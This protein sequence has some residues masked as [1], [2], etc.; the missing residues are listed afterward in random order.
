M[1]FPQ[2]NLHQA[3]TYWAK[4][5]QNQF[6]PIFA[7]PVALKGR[8]IEEQKLFIDAAGREVR[9]EAIVTLNTDVAN[10]GYLF[11]GT[12]TTANPRAVSDAKII[13]NFEKVPTIKATAFERTAF[14]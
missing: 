4:S 2:D 5:G 6:G 7:A 1:A 9:S 11:L 3:V 8:W 10:E 12:S 13:K 14:L